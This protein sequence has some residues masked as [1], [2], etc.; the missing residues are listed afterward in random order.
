MGPE[1]VSLTAPAIDQAPELIQSDI[2]ASP[3]VAML[4]LWSWVLRI[5]CQILMLQS[6][7]NS[8]SRASEAVR[9]LVM[10]MCLMLLV[11]F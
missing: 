11:P 6:S 3:A 4:S 2:P 5:Q 7:R 1:G 8:C 10:N 9:T